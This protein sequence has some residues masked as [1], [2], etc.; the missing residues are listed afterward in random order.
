MLINRLT[1]TTSTIGEPLRSPE[2]REE[3]RAEVAPRIREINE[4]IR[5]GWRVT[6]LDYVVYTEGEGLE[7]AV[8]MEKA[9]PGRA[10][11]G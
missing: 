6:G 2:V 5:N 9:G 10:G 3:L 8:I 4:L 11:E 7:L 1:I